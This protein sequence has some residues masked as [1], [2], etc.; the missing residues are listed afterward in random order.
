MP[1]TAF[2]IITP[3]GIDSIQE[4]LEAAY[5]EKALLGEPE[6][7]VR[8]VQIPWGAQDTFCDI[9]NETGSVAKSKRAAEAQA[10][11]TNVT[12]T[13]EITVTHYGSARA[14][15]TMRYDGSDE[16]SAHM[17]NDIKATLEDMFPPAF[18]YAVSLKRHETATR[19]TV[20]QGAV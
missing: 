4:T 13:H 14:T 10:R 11:E 8:I 12:T 15:V 18:G 9:Y 2:I 19:V 16:G 6:W 5:D 3:E 7:P 1:D 17:A 20:L